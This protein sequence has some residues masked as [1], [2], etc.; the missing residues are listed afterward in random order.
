MMKRRPQY[1][2]T[3]LGRKLTLQEVEEHHCRRQKRKNPNKRTRKRQLFKC[4]RL[5]IA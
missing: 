1:F 3:K 4:T 2:C 5:I